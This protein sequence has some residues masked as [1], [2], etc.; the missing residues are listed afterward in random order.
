[1]D[2][3]LVNHYFEVRG[4]KKYHVFQIGTRW[5]K[6]KQEVVCSMNG[7]KL[8]EKYVDESDMAKLLG[9]SQREI[10]MFDSLKRT[11]Y[12]CKMALAFLDGIRWADEH[13]LN[14]PK[15]Q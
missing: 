7:F 3:R 9:I 10:D 2:Y 13:P 6:D 1:M 14:A 4:W 12:T 11:G 15:K 8:N 5:V